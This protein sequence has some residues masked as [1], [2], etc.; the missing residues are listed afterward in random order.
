MPSQHQSQGLNN[1]SARAAELGGSLDWGADDGVF[2]V[3]AQL[4]LQA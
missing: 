4:P 1:M 3:R 2:R